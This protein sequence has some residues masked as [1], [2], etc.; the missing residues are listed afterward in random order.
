MPRRITSKKITGTTDSSGDAT[1]YSQPF[2]GKILAVHLD[3]DSLD[4]GADTTVS[5]DGELA[6]QTVLSRT[7]S[8]T[9]ETA[10]PRTPAQDASGNDVTFD[11]TNEIYTEF[12]TNGRLKAVIAQGGNAKAFAITALV[13]EY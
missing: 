6:A 13:E 3:V 1:A 5:T 11:G 7:N 10:Y 12:V 2:S 9:N 8:N 4:A